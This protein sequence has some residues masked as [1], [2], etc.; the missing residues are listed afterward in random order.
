MIKRFISFLLLACLC[1]ACFAACGDSTDSSD[2]GSVSIDDTELSEVASGTA[3]EEVSDE[4]SGPSDITVEGNAKELPAL[5]EEYP[6]VVNKISSTVYRVDCASAEEGQ[7]LQLTFTEKDWGTWNLG[8]WRLYSSDGK[9]TNFVSG[10][11]DWEYVYRS[12]KDSGSW[13]WSGGNHGNEKLISLKFYNG[14]TDEEIK[15]SMGDSR[16]VNVLRIVE[17]TQL[18]WGDT[19]DTYCDVVRTYTIT[20]PQIIL[21]VDYEYTQDCY[22]WLSYTC[23]FPIEKKYGLWCDMIGVD[24]NLIKTIETLKVGAADYSGPMNSGNA[25]WRADIYGYEDDRYHFDIRVRTIESSLEN[26]TNAFK[27]AFWDMNTGT[28]K[29]Y[30][31]KFDQNTPTLVPAGTTLSTQCLW[32][33]SVEE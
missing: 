6:M 32:Y 15:M 3:S 23:M 12:G 11:T 33:F 19:E 20:G 14:E 24:N 4:A 8:A 22:H 21:D 27:T 29:L 13:V 7:T 31:S 30:F 28:N 17:K 25:A 1:T 18:H 16:T 9:Y 5:L 26:M 2:S 10:S